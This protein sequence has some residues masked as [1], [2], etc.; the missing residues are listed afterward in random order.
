MTVA[1]RLSALFRTSF[2]LKALPLVICL[3]LSGFIT[4]A[5][6]SAVRN[7]HLMMEHSMSALTAM[8]R[9]LSILQDA[10]TGQRGYIITGD[11]AYLAPYESAKQ[12]LAESLI[13]LDRLIFK[14]AEQHSA[15]L[16][17]QDIADKK[18]AEMANTIAV[19]DRNGFDA[20]RD[21]VAK[22]VGRADMDRLRDVIAGMKQRERAILNDAAEATDSR[23]SKL[24][25][26]AFGA[27]GVSLVGRVISA[28][29]RPRGRF[30]RR[31]DLSA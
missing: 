26:A 13:E 28:T 20:A 25:L 14:N 24:I 17:I 27:L 21:L 3:A 31:K 30:R 18:M 11:K 22:D 10:E 15:V 19:R 29:I 2:L 12:Y 1:T 16:E 6:N 4:F 8:D 9:T 23:N 5:Y 7:G